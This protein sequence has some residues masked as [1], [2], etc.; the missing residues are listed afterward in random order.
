MNFNLMDNNKY[1][2]IP[3]INDENIVINKKRKN[4]EINIIN[5]NI[6]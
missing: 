2:E 6:E 5:N 1:K 4:N 3:I